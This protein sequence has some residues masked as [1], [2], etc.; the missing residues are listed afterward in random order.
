MNVQPTLNLI[1][2]IHKLP[3]D[4]SF[5]IST[6]IASPQPP[7][8]MNDVRDYYELYETYR[9]NIND[10]PT[11]TSPS[12][13]M[14]LDIFIFAARMMLINDDRYTHNIYDILMRDTRYHTQDAAYE[15][16]AAVYFYRN[17]RTSFML[18][19]GLMTHPERT[20]FAT[21]SAVAMTQRAS[22]GL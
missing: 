6:Y 10:G 13:M 9:I 5:L 15:H 14:A 19:W 7:E 18:F 12:T 22:Q 20:T 1:D 16:M 2:Q 17:A 4:L 8:L 11:K 3:K 21:Y